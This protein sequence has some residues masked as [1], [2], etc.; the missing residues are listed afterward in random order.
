MEVSLVEVTQRVVRAERFAQMS[1]YATVIDHE[2]KRFFWRIV[3][4]EHA[5]DARDGLQQS[6]LFHR[7]REVEDRV[8][9]RIEAGQELVDHDQDIRITGTLERGDDV[10]VVAFLS[11]MPVHHPPP[12]L[13]D[14]VVGFFVDGLFAFA[15]VRG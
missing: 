8:P 9:W 15:L 7:A 3:F 10:L 12:E 11:A 2:A 13:D 4:V 5:I 1:Q 6:M 14:L